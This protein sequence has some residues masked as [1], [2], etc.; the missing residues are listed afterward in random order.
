M[1]ISFRLLFQKFSSSAY[2]TQQA[3]VITDINK[4]GKVVDVLN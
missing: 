1:I 3:P 4:K 2:I